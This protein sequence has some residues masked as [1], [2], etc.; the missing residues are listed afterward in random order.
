VRC[1]QGKCLSLMRRPESL[2][3]NHNIRSRALSS[4]LRRAKQTERTTK[5]IT[6]F[7]IPPFSKSEALISL[8]PAYNFLPQRKARAGSRGEL[9][10]RG[11]MIGQ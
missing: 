9:S 7:H 1:D 5:K 8:R 10:A 3:L 11:I 4:Q 2:P 6:P